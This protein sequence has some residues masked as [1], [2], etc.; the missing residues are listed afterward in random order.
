MGYDCIIYYYL[1]KKFEK[2]KIYIINV[3][4]TPMENSIMPDKFLGAY[5]N[6]YTKGKTYEEAVKKVLQKLGDDGLY[7]KEICEPIYEMESG[8]WSTHIEE[9]F[10]KYKQNLPTQ[11]EF[12]NSI[13]LDEVVYGAFGSYE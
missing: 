11:E 7:T 13:A 8:S 9:N 2:M 4:I 12:E 6:C 3:H 5:V 10:S 1:K